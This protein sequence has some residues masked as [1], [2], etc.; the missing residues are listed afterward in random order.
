MKKRLLLI[1]PFLL[2][3]LGC[4][5]IQKIKDNVPIKE[6]TIEPVLPFDEA[7]NGTDFTSGE[8]AYILDKGIFDTINTFEASIRMPKDVKERSIIFGNYCYYNDISSNNYSCN[9][10]I[11]IDGHLR[12]YWKQQDIV[13]NNYNF[14]NNTWTHL[15][16]VRNKG[17]QT[18]TLYVNGELIQT[19]SKSVSDL[20]FSGGFR[21]RIGGDAREGSRKYPFQGEIGSIS[22]YK[23][24]H[25]QLQIMEDY[26]DVRDISYATRGLDLIFHTVLSNHED[27]LIDTSNNSNHARAMTNDYY[28]E[29]ELYDS[30]DYSFGVVGDT[31]V[32][33]EFNKSAISTYADWAIN[34]KEEKNLQAMLFMGD[35]TNGTSSTEEPKWE[36]M[37][38]TVSTE[39]S[40]MDDKVPYIFVPG[41]HDY[42]LDSN[43]RDL[44]MFNK[45]FPYS[46]YSKNSYFG[47]AYEEGQTQNTYYTFEVM[48]IK[49]LI[50]AME[51][52]PEKAV[53]DWM[54]QVI[55]DHSDYRVIMITHGFLNTNGEMYSEDTYLSANWYFSR[56]GYES[57]SSVQFWNDHLSKHK[58]LFM[59]LCGHSVGESIAWKMLKGD[60]GNTVMTFRLDPSYV[61]ASLGFDPILGLFNFNESKKEMTINYFSMEKNLCYNVQN[62][63]RVNFETFDVKT[64]SYFH[65]NK[66]IAR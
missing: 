59:I 63:I 11:N 42:L 29:G 23:T 49:Y 52:G 13:F 40:K 50:M 64:G 55:E 41:N 56:H 62:Q 16:V 46:K 44:T 65:P 37:W 38:Q 66:E 21:M 9:F 60:K 25:T 47:G 33:T 31:Q 19:L 12:V 48:G 53:L 22:A 5:N 57:T 51:F 26:S 17:E 10:E 20:P 39:M 1:I 30:A 6:E 45:Y 18:F 14:F 27:I 43:Y 35:L 36:K 58:N 32:L 3:L 24:T 7:Y 54:D 28:F 34:N 2:P 8:L 61:I 4:N 15:A